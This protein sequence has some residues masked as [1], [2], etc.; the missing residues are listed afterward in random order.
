[1]DRET[2]IGMR[3]A[4]A[5]AIVS[6]IISMIAYGIMAAASPISS[7]VD[8]DS[9]IRTIVMASVVQ[10]VVLAVL[11]VFFLND[12]G[13]LE[14]FTK[15]GLLERAWLV[16][17]LGVIT[18]V[19]AGALL[20]YALSAMFLTWEEWLALVDL[21]AVYGPVVRLLAWSIFIQQL[22]FAL[23]VLYFLLA[24]RQARAS[25]PFSALETRGDVLGIAF[26]VSLPVPGTL[27]VIS[28]ILNTLLAGIAGIVSMALGI[29]WL[30]LHS[31]ALKS[32]NLPDLPED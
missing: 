18:L 21:A 14:N 12:A 8:Y 32:R 1:M 5:G 6:F 15:A 29:A 23:P 9:F 30:V 10:L 27:L 11:L 26:T 19:G 31:L 22:G 13:E 25:I 28:C 20:G 16:N 7:Y 4:M 3:V 17:T 2:A 24:K